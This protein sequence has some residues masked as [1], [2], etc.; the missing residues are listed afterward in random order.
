[1]TEVRFYHLQRTTLDKALPE[2]LEKCVERDW[3]TVVQIGSPER[4]RALDAHLWSY[5]DE[6][7]LPHGT[8][9]DGDPETQPVFLTTGPENPNGAEV[10]FLIDDPE[11][12]DLAPYR[13]AVVLFDG[14]DEE[15]VLAARAR[16]KTAKA[17]GFEV[18]YMQ[19]DERGRWEK[20][21]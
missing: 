7:F 20:K 16:W 12:P 18:S 1:M 2:L 6:A 13:L 3:P 15:A 17:A 11:A 9:E 14:N 8:I 21:A 5:A 10:R 19:Q 4:L